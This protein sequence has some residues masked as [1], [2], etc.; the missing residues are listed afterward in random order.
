MPDLQ[1]GIPGPVWQSVRS[2]AAQAPPAA[3]PGEVLR[4]VEEREAARVTRD[5]AA[6]DALREQALALGWQIQDTPEGPRP[7]PA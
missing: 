6:A 4:L 7:L 2:A 5:W 3:P 1:A